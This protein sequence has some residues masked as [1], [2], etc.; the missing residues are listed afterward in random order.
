ME[1]LPRAEPKQ[2]KGLKRVSTPWDFLNSVFAKYKPDTEKLLN[3]C[4]LF[5]WE[6]TRIEK[7]LKNDDASIVTCKEYLRKNY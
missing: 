5:D 7:L 3:E 4:F 6:R 1:V 2:L